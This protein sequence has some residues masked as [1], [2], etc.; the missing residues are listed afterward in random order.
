MA[1]GD[2]N[3]LPSFSM[4]ASTNAGCETGTSTVATLSDATAS[5]TG[6]E[7]AVLPPFAA[8]T[9]ASIAKSLSP[10]IQSKSFTTIFSPSLA[11]K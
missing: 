7:G 9:I 11:P 4:T 10:I 1:N 5:A 3:I 8:E 6:C 2:A